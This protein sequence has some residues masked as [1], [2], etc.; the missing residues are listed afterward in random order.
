[1]K[2]K[3]TSLRSVRRVLISIRPECRPVQSRVTA[4]NRLARDV[5]RSHAELF[6]PCSY[7]RVFRALLSIL[8]LG[9]TLKQIY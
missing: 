5:Q 9:E 3:V 4:R 8:S 2:C 6:H 1:M 7:D